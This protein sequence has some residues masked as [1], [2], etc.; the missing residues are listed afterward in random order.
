[1]L[2]HWDSVNHLGRLAF[3]I[4]LKLWMIDVFLFNSAQS[5]ILLSVFSLLRPLALNLN[6]HHSAFLSPSICRPTKTFRAFVFLL[7][8]RFSLKRWRIFFRFR[9]KKDDVELFSV[10]K[11]IAW[12]MGW[13][14]NG[15]KKRT[16][17]KLFFCQ[18]FLP[19]V[20]NE[21]ATIPLSIEV[22]VDKMSLR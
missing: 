10:Q 1:M 11:H 14:K 16:L 15:E 18:F 2:K 12:N 6:C 5:R 17:L 3:W 7:F 21:L 20:H 4:L 19:H 9:A 8:Y 22:W 13:R